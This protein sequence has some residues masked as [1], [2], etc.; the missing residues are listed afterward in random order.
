MENIKLISLD[1][2]HLSKKT[3]SRTLGGRPP[4]L[5]AHCRHVH[6]QRGAG[7]EVRCGWVSGSKV[8][9]PSWLCCCNPDVIKHS[10]LFFL[11]SPS[12]L[13]PLSPPIPPSSLPSILFYPSFLSILSCFLLSLPL[14]K[15]KHL[16]PSLF[17]SLSSLF[18]SS[19]TV[20][21]TLLFLNLSFS[22]F[23]HPHR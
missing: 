2:I 5:R 19:S 23:L 14:Y 12:F 17:S 7:S 9:R 6:A 10:H 4:P 1:F 11:S 13:T 22:T 16:L 3:K 21:S 18:S 15:M 20:S 8:K